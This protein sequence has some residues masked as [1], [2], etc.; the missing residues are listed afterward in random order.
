MSICKL[1]NQRKYQGI[2][3]LVCQWMAMPLPSEEN[4]LNA[5]S[6]LFGFLEYHSHPFSA[7]WC[8]RKVLMANRLNKKTTRRLRLAFIGV[9]ILL[10]I[11]AILVLLI[12]CINPPATMPMILRSIHSRF[13]SSMT[14]ANK[15]Q[16]VS[17][18]NVPESFL[19]CVWQSEDRH[20]L[21]HFGFDWEEIQNAR[22]EAKATGKLARGASTMTQ[23]CARS[24]LELLLPKK[25][26][27]ELY[28][29]VIE[30]GDGIYGLE[31][32][33]HHYYGIAAISMTKEESA[34]LVAIMPNPKQW[35]PNKPGE[36]VLRRQKVILERG[37]N[38]ALPERL[39]N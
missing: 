12:R 17:I 13:D 21:E 38:V 1:R 22:E 29:N 27:F 36:R 23:Q 3:D 32:A 8:L 33:S 24:L 18:R 26:I 16:W 9:L 20:F 35:D 5:N 19:T 34:M 30:L 6:A 11:P 28:I 31:A 7:C 14:H 2:R 39:R 4:S 10:I 15:F 25:R 37:G